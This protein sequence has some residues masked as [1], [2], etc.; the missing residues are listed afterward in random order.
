VKAAVLVFAAFLAVAADA[1]Y[2]GYPPPPCVPASQPDPAYPL[3]VHILGINWNRNGWGFHGWGRANLLGDNPIGLEYTFSC[4]QRPMYN[5]QADEFYQA[6]WKKP[7]QKMEILMQEV[8][9]KHVEK[10]DLM[11]TEHDR[12]FVLGPPRSVQ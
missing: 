2:L 3:H 9:G 4:S 8:G 6:R 10:C 7:H 11:V 12:P 5:A 1:Q